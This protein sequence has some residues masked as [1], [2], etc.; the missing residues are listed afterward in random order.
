MPR[1]DFSGAPEYLPKA[2]QSLLVQ[3]TAFVNLLMEWLCLPNKEDAEKVPEAEVSLPSFSQKP[4]LGNV[5][6]L[7]LEMGAEIHDWVHLTWHSS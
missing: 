2:Y 6:V 3:K 4:T 7:A 1:K 5:V